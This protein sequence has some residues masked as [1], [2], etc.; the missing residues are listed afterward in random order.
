MHPPAHATIR[1]LP[2]E[3]AMS[4]RPF[5]CLALVAFA[6]IARPEDPPPDRLERLQAIYSAK[7]DWCLRAF[8]LLGIAAESDDRVVGLLEPGLDDREA[9]VRG[10]AAVALRDLPEPVLRA[11]ADAAYVERLLDRY[12]VSK[13]STLEL[14]MAFDHLKALSG[15]D[16]GRNLTRWKKW[17]AG[18]KPTW[19]PVPVGRIERP[20][21]AGAA[22]RTEALL[23]R[24]LDLQT[25]GLDLVLAVDSTGSMG[26]YIGAAKER[27][28]D[29]ISLLA[30]VIPAARLRM[31][32]ITYDDSAVVRCELT[33][34]LE[35]VRKRLER[36]E[37][38]GGGDWHEGVDRAVQ[39]AVESHKMPWR[40]EAAKVLIVCGDAAA[41]DADAPRV[42]ALA[43][44]MH[45]TPER[46]AK[47]AYSGKPGR[48]K[49]FLVSCV[50][51]LLENGPAGAALD[52]G[53]ALA[54]TLAETFFRELARRGGGTYVVASKAE[55]VVVQLLVLSFGVEWREEI[56]RFVR[57]F[58]E[59]EAAP[60]K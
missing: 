5:A 32:L 3:V 55:E 56:E 45:R 48:V 8:A 10:T 41:H 53:E 30:A 35:D 19:Q 60:R 26:P 1:A 28:G 50:H 14:E 51:T 57:C 43:E 58:K 7:D 40:R 42:H 31:G 12:V 46:L 11:G 21:D 44:S 27:L 54:R 34:K 17:W 15:E 20:K 37:A 6:T 24:I 36:V 47:V 22:G 13:R 23:D 33:G 2:P 39:E 49:P 18:A 4:F 38:V 29:L 25:D 9:R 52:P 16:H 59:I